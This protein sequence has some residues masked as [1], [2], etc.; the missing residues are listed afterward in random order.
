MLLGQRR[1]EFTLKG[2][3][4]RDFFPSLG[5]SGKILEKSVHRS[6]FGHSSEMGGCAGAAAPASP[7]PV[8]G[9]PALPLLD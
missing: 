1:G 8:M 6:S 4:H 3:V 5:K 7:G 9:G 2:D